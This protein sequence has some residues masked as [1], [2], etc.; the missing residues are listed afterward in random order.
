[1]GLTLT[2]CA[3]F[4]RPGTWR[5]T[6]AS[7]EDLAQQVANP[8]DL[9]AG[10]G[11]SLSSGVAATAGIDKALGAGGEGTASGLQTAATHVMSSVN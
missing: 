8:S 3:P 7:R 10:H 9:I 5:I 4:A 2:G 1:M 6:G 11:N